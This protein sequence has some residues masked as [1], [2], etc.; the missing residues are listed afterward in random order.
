MGAYRPAGGMPA[1]K[2]GD[3]I[4]RNLFTTSE[5]DRARFAAHGCD[6]NSVVGDALFVD[7]A[8]GDFR[9]KEGSPALALGFVNFPMDRFG[10]RKPELKAIARAP[11]IPA[12]RKAAPPAQGVGASPVLPLFWQGAEIRA[13]EGEE[14]SAYGV[15]RES[16]G[17][18][19]KGISPQ[20]PL[21]E[22]GLRNQDLIQS[23]NGKPVRDVEHLLRETDAA[24]GRPLAL[25]FVRGQQ[26]RQA[27]LSDY[28]FVMAE[29][30]PGPAFG[31]IPLAPESAIVPFR[32]MKAR[33]D[34]LNEPLTALKDG[35]LASNYGPVFGNDVRQG[36]YRLDLGRVVELA[37]I[38]TWSFSQN[39]NR[40]AQRFALYASEAEADPGWDPADGS[41]Y[42]PI[43]EVRA[44]ASDRFLATG[45]RRS[46]G[47]ALGACRWLLWVAQPVT[48]IGENTAFQEFQ[49][50]PAKPAAPG[51]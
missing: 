2:W 22:A 28:T 33:P 45:I 24:A 15:S 1:G 46:E 51:R 25:G 31:Q 32:S 20:S 21:T 40:G 44:S 43:A 49:A 14:Y 5:A 36:C 13:L 29:A 30:A 17:V 8:R 23:A 4:D 7:P 47:R 9:V 26:A 12:L 6:S 42:R 38:R 18:L 50:L 27:R 41:R 34:T 10:V 37:E 35:K 48:A 19:L 3:R 11:E 16:G 39:G